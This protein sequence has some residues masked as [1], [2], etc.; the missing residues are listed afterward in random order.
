L[1]C[2]VQEKVYQDI[3]MG[4]SFGVLSDAGAVRLCSTIGRGRFKFQYGSV[5]TVD[6]RLFVW[7]F[8][9]DLRLLGRDGGYNELIF[10]RSTYTLRNKDN[11]TRAVC[12]I[13]P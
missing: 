10:Q 11:E 3:G 2:F 6:G 8:T 9:W 4:P 12:T 7:N 5:R 13:E 1:Q